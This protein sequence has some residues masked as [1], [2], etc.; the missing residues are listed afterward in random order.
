IH[1]G[2]PPQSR[3]QQRRHLANLSPADSS[4]SLCYIAIRRTA[5]NQ[6]AR[7][8]RTERNIM[9]EG[10]REPCLE[11]GGGPT[12][13]E[14]FRERKIYAQLEFDS[15]FWA[16]GSRRSSTSERPIVP[17]QQGRNHQIHRAEQV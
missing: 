11:A 4:H 5:S 9:P 17:Y 13:R 14:D 16:V 15:D 12:T 8:R 1:R 10:S 3:C 6:K 2:C 7:L